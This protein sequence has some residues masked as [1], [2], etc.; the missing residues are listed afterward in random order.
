MTAHDIADP[1]DVRRAAAGDDVGD[2]PEV[3]RAQQ[4]RTDDREETGVSLAAV[5][6]SVDHAPRYEECLARAQV[7]AGSADG[8]RGDAVQPEDGL[9]ELVVA[10]R[11]GAGTSHSKMLTLPPDSSAST[12]KRTERAPSWI[13]SAAVSGMDDFYSMPFKNASTRSP[14]SAAAAS[15]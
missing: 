8:K 14:S 15:S 9:V 3:A 1:F 11:R 4:T 5:A 12:W 6:E 7:G 2:L 10:V 13:G